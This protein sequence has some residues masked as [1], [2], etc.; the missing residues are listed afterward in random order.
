MEPA[1]VEKK[2]AKGIRRAARNAMSH[3]D[4]LETFKETAREF[5]HMVINKRFASVLHHIYTVEQRKRGLVPYDDKRYLLANLENG[6]PNPAT[7]AY[8]H[9]S[10]IGVEVVVVDAPPDVP[11]APN[12]QP[13]PPEDDGEDHL[14]LAD[15]AYLATLEPTRDQLATTRWARMRAGVLRAAGILRDAHP[16]I[17]EEIDREENE[18]EEAAI[19]ET[20][21]Y[22]EITDAQQR[23]LGEAAAARVDFRNERNIDRR[24]CCAK[25]VRAPAPHD[26]TRVRLAI[27]LVCCDVMYMVSFHIATRTTG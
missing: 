11:L 24:D 10:V 16:E 13:V 5:P 4:Y 3:R 1:L 23:I 21:E 12:G 7:H 20:G 14:P 19:A 8:G 15:R 18:A 27:A 22:P 6:S 9:K 25:P 26:G 2:T 17:V